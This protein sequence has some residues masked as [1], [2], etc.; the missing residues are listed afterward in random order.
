M[1]ARLQSNENNRSVLLDKPIVFVGR[2]PECD[3]IINNSRK[4]SRKHCCFAE[5]NGR[6]VLRD[7][8]ST[9][10]VQINNRRVAG[11]HE[12]RHGDEVMIGDCAYVFYEGR[13]A[14][15]PRSADLAPEVIPNDVSYDPDGDIHHRS[16]VQPGVDPD[17]LSGE[18]PVM[19]NEDDGERESDGFELF[20]E[21]GSAYGRRRRRAGSD[22]QMELAID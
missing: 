12:L 11:A 8:G 20:G 5:V 17:E 1:P 21:P 10:G 9:N 7:L 13:L 19:L 18:M 2:H 16:P 3:V 14:P 15:E 4:V 22:S 6:Y